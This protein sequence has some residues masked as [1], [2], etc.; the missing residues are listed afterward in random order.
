MM[1]QRYVHPRA[2]LSGAL[3]E[4]IA[5]CA[6]L[7]GIRRSLTR[8]LPFPVLLSDVV[9]VV[10]A[11]WLVDAERVQSFL[12]KGAR[13]WVRDGRTPFTVLSYRHGHFGPALAGPLR[14]CFPSPLQSN[15]RLY[16]ENPL[17]HAPDVPTV[18]FVKNVIDNVSYVLGT[19]V[20]SDS[21]PSHLSLRFS[22]EIAE[23]SIA[24]D[25]HPGAGSAPRLAMTLARQGSPSLPARFDAFGRTWEELVARLTLQ[26]AAVVPRA[27]LDAVALG[28][29]RLPIDLD[30]VEPLA[31]E[32]STLECPLLDALGGTSEAICFRVPK[33]RFEVLSDRLL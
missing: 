18:V 11:T 9:D 12:P 31:L 3:I 22:M 16:L 24:L 1:D 29:I 10:Y 33:V 19:R 14:R 5:N 27:D 2:G 26:D 30:S 13:L 15:W 8:H 17:P 7:A 25:L 23:R 20:F 32:C 28:T 21:L 6:T 4:R